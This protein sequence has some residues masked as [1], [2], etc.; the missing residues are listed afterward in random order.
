[1]EPKKEL[2][3]ETFFEAVIN[4]VSKGGRVVGSYAVAVK[5]IDGGVKFIQITQD[6]SAY[7]NKPARRTSITLDPKNDELKKAIIEAFKH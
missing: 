2:P 1:M 7:G 3:S 6:K 4:K 5:S